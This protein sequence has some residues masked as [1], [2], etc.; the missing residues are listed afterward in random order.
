MK[1]LLIATTN[2][3]KVREIK[4]L[5]ASSHVYQDVLSLK[6]A[7]ISHEV[8]EDGSTF[9]E[10]A[11]KKAVEISL[12]SDYDVLADD[13]G[14]CVL[15]LG[16]APGVF[17]ARYS[18]EA[19][20]EA[21]NAKLILEVSALREQDRSAK[22]V[23]AIALAS[24]GKLLFVCEGECS[25]KILLTPQGTGGFGYDPLFYVQEYGDTFGNIPLEIKNR[26][27]HRARALTKFEAYLNAK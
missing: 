9:A 14:L 23:C 10:N 18:H 24:K 25:G 6:E 20:D 13:S 21:N 12:I 17:S 26:I 15:G 1:K 22:Y 8:I 3:G 27:S 5:L 7:G 11:T 16:G 2:A 4:K 19:T